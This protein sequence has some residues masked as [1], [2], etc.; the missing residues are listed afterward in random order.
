M[1]FSM[2]IITI[3]YILL[4]ELVLSPKVVDSTPNVF[5]QKFR[6]LIVTMLTLDPKRGLGWGGGGAG[7]GGQLRDLPIGRTGELVLF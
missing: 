5:Y 7:G 4:T 6:L 2:R 1:Y 3:P